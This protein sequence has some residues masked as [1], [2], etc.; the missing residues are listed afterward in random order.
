MIREN[1]NCDI[2][3]EEFTKLLKPFSDN[4]NEY[5]ESYIMPEVSAYYIANSYYRHS[6]YK[7]SFLQHYN[8]A[9][10][11]I[12]YFSEDYEKV[13]VEVYRLLRVK[14]ALLIINENS[15]EIKKIEYKL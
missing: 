1:V 12:N 3:D 9:K 8:S 13:K 7:G 4:Y 2:S 14:Y 10:D 15:L 5:L 11:I 6:M